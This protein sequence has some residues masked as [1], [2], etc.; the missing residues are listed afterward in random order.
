M[1]EEMFGAVPEEERERILLGN[2]VE[3]FHL[4]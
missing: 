1:I 2:A 4:Q 3:F